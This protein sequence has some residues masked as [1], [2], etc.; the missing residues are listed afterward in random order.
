MVLDL[1]VYVV[2]QVTPRQLFHYLAA[3]VLY[4]QVFLHV[5]LGYLPHSPVLGTLTTMDQVDPHPALL[6]LL[7]SAGGSVSGH[8]GIDDLLRP[9]GH[10]VAIEVVPGD[11]M[12]SHIF[13]IER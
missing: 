10:V 11:A 5:L 9:L 6:V 7:G 3:R 4:H 13:L 8:E 1:Q 2:V 12:H